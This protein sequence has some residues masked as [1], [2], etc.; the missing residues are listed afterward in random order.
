MTLIPKAVANK[1]KALLP[2]DGVSEDELFKQE[3]IAFRVMGRQVLAIVLVEEL[4]DVFLEHLMN[5]GIVLVH[6]D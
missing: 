5:T 3:F 1:K 4:S 2:S 6:G